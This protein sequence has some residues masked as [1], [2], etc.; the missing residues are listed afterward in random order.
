MQPNNIDMS[1]IREA[2]QRRAQ[3]GGGT[4]PSQQMSV[5]QNGQTPLQVPPQ[6]GAPG[7]LASEQPP[8]QP[9]A[10]QS[11]QQAPGQAEAGAGGQN[12]GGPFDDGTKAISKALIARLLKVL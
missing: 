1:A 8:Q 11:P 5:P 4:P 6:T 3:G 2:L 10:P 7:S 12:A 9:A